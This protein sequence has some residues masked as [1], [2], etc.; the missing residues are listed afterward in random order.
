MHW[1]GHERV[2]VHDLQNKRVAADFDIDCAVRLP[3]ALETDVKIARLTAKEPITILVP[4]LDNTKMLETLRN[5]RA[6]LSTT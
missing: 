1:V 6:K 2:L 5:K 3:D 4:R